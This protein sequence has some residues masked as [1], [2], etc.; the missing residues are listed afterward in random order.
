VVNGKRVHVD[1]ERKRLET[2]HTFE[3]NGLGKRP[4]HP[5][6]SLGNPQVE[7]I[8]K[9]A[10]A[11]DAFGCELR[12]GAVFFALEMETVGLDLAQM[13]FHQEEKNDECS[14]NDE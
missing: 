1:I 14:P 4:G 3:F 11:D 12:D 2:A 7:G 6:R 5:E 8:T 9:R 10:G 13:D